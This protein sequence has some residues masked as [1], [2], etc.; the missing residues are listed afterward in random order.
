MRDMEQ[1]A[2]GPRVRAESGAEAGGSRVRE[3]GAGRATQVRETKEAKTK[4]RATQASVGFRTHAS[5]RTLASPN[6]SCN[7][8]IFI[9]KIFW[10]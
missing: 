9:R 7:V 3:G 4:R 2:G 6:Y 1:G 8:N 10:F 5:V